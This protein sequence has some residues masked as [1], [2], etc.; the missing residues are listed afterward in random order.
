[1][2]QSF[3]Q[4]SAWARFQESLGRK[5][6]WLENKLVIKYALPLGLSYLYS[7]RPHFAKKETF[8]DFLNEAGR[9]AK[10]ENAIFLRLEPD[11]NSML[12]ATSY[13]LH[14]TTNIQPQDTL[15]LNLGQS[16]TR[17]LKEMHPK[18]RYNIRVAEKHKIKIRKTTAPQDIDIF[19]RLAL[20]TSQRDGFRYHPKRYYQKMIE[21]LGK[22]K[23]AELYL[24]YLESPKLQTLNTEQV[25]SPKS[26]IRNNSATEQF[27]NK[28]T[29]PLAAII[30]LFYKDTA[31]YLHGASDYQHRRY[32]APYLLQW[33]AIKDA[34]KR[35]NKYYDFWGITPHPENHPWAGITR[36]KTGF[37]PQGEIITYPQCFDIVYQP[38]WYLLYN[39]LRKLQ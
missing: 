2:N 36:F 9:L 25:Q 31:V 27:S 19:W 15:I 26:Q 3:L 34:K 30:V 4:S 12:H 24:A 17:L 22:N 33:E 5:I 39:L 18:T 37:A 6:F 28:A 23:M 7:P 16:E 38:A 32:M 20:K 11:L 14:E 1:M 13:T 21:V 10:K 8:K 29:I 35:G